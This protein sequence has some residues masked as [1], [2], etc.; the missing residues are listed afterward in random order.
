[1]DRPRYAKTV[2]VILTLT[3][4]FFLVLP[5]PFKV[6]KWAC[7]QP[8][9]SV[10][11]YSMN[12]QTRW[13]WLGGYHIVPDRF[14]PKSSGENLEMFISKYYGVTYGGVFVLGIASLMLGVG[15]YFGTRKLLGRKAAMSEAE[16]IN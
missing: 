3:L 12:E 4:I 8:C 10:S 14:L 1:M 15:T 9:S 5:Y 11:D 13:S 6:N 7:T 2:L 16:V